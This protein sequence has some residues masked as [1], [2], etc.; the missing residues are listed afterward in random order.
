MARAGE[1]GN[2]HGK[3]T[4]RPADVN[5]GLASERKAREG[6]KDQIEQIIRAERQ[7]VIDDDGLDFP[8]AAGCGFED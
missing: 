1:T 4:T 7:E 5:L 2:F 3:T 6:W 8:L